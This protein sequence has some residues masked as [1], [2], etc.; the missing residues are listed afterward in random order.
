MTST[1]TGGGTFLLTN[2]TESGTIVL[3]RIEDNVCSITPLDQIEISVQESPSI[4]NNDLSEEICSGST[5]NGF[6]ITSDIS[7]TFSWTRT[8]L[9]GL[10]TNGT[11][12]IPSETLSINNVIADTVNYEVIPTGPS[13]NNCVGESVDFSLVV[14]PIPTITNNDLAEEICSETNSSGFLLTADVSNTNFTW[15]STRNLVEG[16]FTSTGTDNI[17]SER[18]IASSS[19]ENGLITYE[20]I[21]NAAGCVGEPEIF[22]VEVSYIPVI[23]ATVNG[24]NS[25]T[26]RQG[27]ELTLEGSSNGISNRWIVSD[28]LSN[29]IENDTSLVTTLFTEELDGLH[30]ILFESTNGSCSP[31]IPLSI[32]IT[33]PIIAPN[34]FTPNGDD[35][36]D[37]FLIKGIETVP[38][39]EVKIYNRWGGLVYKSSGNYLDDPWDGNNR[40]GGELP[41]G[42]YFYIILLEGS[43]SDQSDGNLV[44]AINILR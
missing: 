17:P 3:T 8:G 35:I 13:P 26:E 22:E 40:R 18:V 29:A 24:G 12:N 30:Q 39:A 2:I 44:G 16:V 33:L 38:G 20:V 9:T 11:G 5:S 10:T 15:T 37:L 43:G 34:S 25:I 41:A 27:E 23:S 42:A 4:T 36:N 7:G 1:E 14:N 19:S 32:N 6:N 21:P 28:E 31:T